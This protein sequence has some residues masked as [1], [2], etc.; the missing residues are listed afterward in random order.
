MAGPLSKARVGHPGAKASGKRK[1][2]Q[3]I[4]TTQ[5]SEKHLALRNGRILN[6]QDDD[7]A[8]MDW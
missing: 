3:Q 4:R 2:K 5:K 8:W 6:D 1:G 7:R